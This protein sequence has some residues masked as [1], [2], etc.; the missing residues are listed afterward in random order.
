M[1]VVKECDVLRKNGWSAQA[2]IR[3]VF[4]Q[5]IEVEGVGPNSARHGRNLIGGSEG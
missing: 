3:I 4:A 5:N 2:W 1:H